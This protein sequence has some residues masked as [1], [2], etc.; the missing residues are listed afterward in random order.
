M[1]VHSILIFTFVYGDTIAF[2]F[3][4]QTNSQNI[5]ECADHS[6][7]LVP[8]HGHGE[9]L[10]EHVHDESSEGIQAGQLMCQV[11]PAG[12]LSKLEEQDPCIYG[13]GGAMEAQNGCNGG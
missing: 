9:P 10:G 7:I 8:E 1:L 3:T 2:F 5:H 11:H 13:W 4:L 6:L 12:L